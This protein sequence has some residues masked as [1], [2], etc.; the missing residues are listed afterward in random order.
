MDEE[1]IMD[2]DVDRLTVEQDTFPPTTIPHLFQSLE[3]T[4]C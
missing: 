4:L 3:S 2:G 1:E